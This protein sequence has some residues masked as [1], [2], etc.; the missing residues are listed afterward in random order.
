[1]DERVF[2]VNKMKKIDGKRV[3]K[4]GKERSTTYVLEA[5]DENTGDR[6]VLKSESSLEADFDLK[7]E[8]IVR[9]IVTGKQKK[10]E[11]GD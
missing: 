3:G 1:M 7:D 2:V 6:L 10:I 9:S 8:V 4:V 5:L 11:G